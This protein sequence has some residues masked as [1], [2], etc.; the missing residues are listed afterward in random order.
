VFTI[1]DFSKITGLTVKTLR[2]YHEQGLLIPTH[3]DPDTGYRYYDRS[4]VETARVITHLRSLDL[5]LEEI[6]AILRTASDDADLRAVME[7]QRSTLEARIRRYRD[8]V[9]SLDQFLKHEDE[10]SRLMA[11]TNFRIEEK[12][13][14]PMLIA[15]IRMKG[16]YADCGAAFARIGKRF[17][18]YVR[19][20]PFLLH[21]DSEFREDDAEFEACM[22][23]RSGQ[24]IDGIAVRELAG[25][26]CVTLFHK[27]PYDQLGRSYAKVIEYIRGKGFG[28]VLPTREVYHKGPGMIFRGNPQNY[29]TEI[30]MPIQDGA[31]PCNPMTGTI[32]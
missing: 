31:T 5:S 11:H 13:T 24:A 2:Y 6:G 26:H 28:I 17:G 8:V 25:A 27:G 4:K 3:V 19:G 1:G 18:R 30:Q 23:I 16:R 9:R 21:Y 22:P 14:E 32:G 20:K 15:G 12:T 10:T 29:L 7:R